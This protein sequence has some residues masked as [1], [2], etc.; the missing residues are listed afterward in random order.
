MCLFYVLAR[1]L[2]DAIESSLHC[3]RSGRHSHISELR[4]IED[5]AQSCL[6]AFF[7]FQARMQEL[8]RGWRSQGRNID[9]QIDRYADGLFRNVRHEVRYPPDRVSHY[10]H[11]MSFVPRRVPGAVKQLRLC[12]ARCSTEHRRATG[13]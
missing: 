6:V 10:A 5:T 9:L 7:A 1:R 8:M 2:H 12:V 4:Q 11:H 13:N 3:H